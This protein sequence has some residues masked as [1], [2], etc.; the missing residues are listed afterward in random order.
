MLT[1]V[2]RAEPGTQSFVKYVNETAPGPRF[3]ASAVYWCKDD[4]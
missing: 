1:L 4:A 2:F 3:D